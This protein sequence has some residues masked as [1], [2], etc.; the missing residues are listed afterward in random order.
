MTLHYPQHSSDDPTAFLNFQ[1]KQ[2]RVRSGPSHSTVSL[3]MLR[4]R[5]SSIYTRIMELDRAYNVPS[6]AQ[7]LDKGNM[8]VKLHGMW[9][10]I[11]R[12]AD[13]PSHY[14][15]SIMFNLRN[16]TRQSSWRPL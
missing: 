8:A 7:A 9:V 15:A 1:F 5:P 3:I 10:T 6:N 11:G 13:H 16:F 14:V 4:P 2:R 12:E